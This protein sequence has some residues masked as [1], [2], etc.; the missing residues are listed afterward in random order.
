[1]REEVRSS[2][3]N[4]LQLASQMNASCWKQILQPQSSLQMKIQPTF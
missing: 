3:I 4:Q 1:M 2:A